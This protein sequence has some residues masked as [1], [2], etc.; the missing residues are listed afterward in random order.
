MLVLPFVEA[1]S[2]LHRHSFVVRVTADLKHPIRLHRGN[3]M[4]FAR[5]SCHSKGVDEVRQG[6][7]GAGLLGVQVYWRLDLLGGVFFK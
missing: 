7:F 4:L 5:V 3:L 1:W 6:Y 2:T